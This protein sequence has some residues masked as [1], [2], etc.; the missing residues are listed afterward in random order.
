[1]T[2]TQFIEGYRKRSEMNQ[3]QMDSFLEDM[4]ALPCQCGETSCKGWAMISNRK[5]IIRAH[6]EL[7]TNT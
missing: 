7:Y 1:M 4:T 5:D 6:K 3:Q 2:K